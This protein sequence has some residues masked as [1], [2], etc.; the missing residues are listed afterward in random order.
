RL[1]ATSKVA[2]SGKKKLP[3][4]GLKTLSEIALSEA[5]QMKL[6]FERSKTQIHSSQPS[7]SGA[8]EGTGVTPGV[9]DVPTYRSDDDEIL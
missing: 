3:A 5:E 4:Q 2:K 9:L 1:K 6:A 8:H 7:G